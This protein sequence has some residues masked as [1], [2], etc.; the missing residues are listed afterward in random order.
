MGQILFSA[1]HKSSGKT[2]V[3]T[4]ICAALR[5]SNKIV[6]P[7]KKGPDYIDPMWLATASQ[8]SCYNLDFWT[9]SN[10]E[11]L[12]LF[13]T[14][15]ADADISII[16]A[17]KGLYDGLALDGS[18]SNAALAKL[19]RSPVVMVLDCRGT[20]RGIAPLL[21]G[22]QQFD[23]EV[24]IQ[25]VILNFVGGDRHEK[26]L[27][28]V[29]EHYTDLKVL[30][31]IRH[32]DALTLEERYLGLIPSNEDLQAVAKTQ[33]L[34]NIIGSQ[35]DLDALV[36]ISTPIPSVHIL[37]KKISASLNLRIGYAK[38]R[39]FG[40]YYPD[41][42]EMF[43]QLGATLVPFDTLHDK[44]LP[45][46]DAVFIGGGFPEKCM[47]ELESNQSMR[48]QINNAL[49]QGLPAYAECGGLMYLCNNIQYQGSSAAMA[50][51][52]DADCIMTPSPEGRGYIQFK[53]NQ[54][55][56]WPPNPSSPIHAH[57]FHYSHLSGLA[58][59]STLVFDVTRGNGIQNK[60]DGIRINNTL[61]CYAHQRHSVHNPWILQFL[62]FV[63]SCQS[64]Q[65]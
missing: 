36:G 25:G 20:I 34:A 61:A 2:I 54:H 56:F 42:L 44:D 16:E 14:K 55:A 31:A 17:N 38:D 18:N 43:Q 32:D 57:E 49:T 26:K 23:T 9:Q 11:I 35:V 27:R 64:R 7:F 30:G 10:Q 52:I 65:A 29:V 19:L 45:A 40:F 12:E 60:Q 4:G 8:R 3:T 39:A 22:Y 33:S 28:Q 13:H 6:Q 53:E 58:E 59:H 48:T 47:S 1:A 21:L 51:V 5:A 50:G 41:D 63:E 62:T 24:N 37:S 15:S 46:V